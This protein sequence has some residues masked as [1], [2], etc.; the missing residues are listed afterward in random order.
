MFF[1]KDFEERMSF[2]NGLLP[3]RPMVAGLGGYVFGRWDRS[4][5]RGRLYAAYRG[6]Q[7]ASVVE[8]FQEASLL[9]DYPRVLYAEEEGPICPQENNTKILLEICSLYSDFPT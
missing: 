9:A 6:I 3:L 1:S 7:Y 8:R 4:E 2:W 5:S